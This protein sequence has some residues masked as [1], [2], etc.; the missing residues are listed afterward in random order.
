MLFLLGT[1]AV[2][3]VL[4]IALLPLGV[5]AWTLDV[6]V[7][8]FFVALP[9]VVG[10]MAWGL[11]FAIR[12]SGERSVP[13]EASRWLAERHT[14]IDPRERK[15]RNRG[16]GWSLWIP[17]L[18][19]LAVLLFLPEI[20]GLVTHIR[21]PQTSQLTGYR[22]PIP[23]TWIILSHDIVPPQGTR[24]SLAWRVADA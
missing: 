1:V 23:A 5:L 16:I 4:V 14:G 24:G 7:M 19:V 18:T 20:W 11:F 17:S 12:K 9:I 3:W 8:L 22:I 6:S 13:I 21:Q 10:G 15:W 2:P